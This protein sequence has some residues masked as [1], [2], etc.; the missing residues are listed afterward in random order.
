MLGKYDRIVADLSPMGSSVMSGKST[1]VFLVGGNADIQACGKG[2]GVFLQESRLYNPTDTVVLYRREEFCAALRTLVQLDT[3]PHTGE[4]GGYI[5]KY[6]SNSLKPPTRSER[7]RDACIG[8]ATSKLKLFACVANA[9][10]GSSP[11]HP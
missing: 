2:T 10:A 3:H 7:H 9:S 1:N 5:F 4:G 8:L 6:F 11:C